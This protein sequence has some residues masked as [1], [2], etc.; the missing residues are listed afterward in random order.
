[1]AMTVQRNT[2]PVSDADRAAIL[3]D[4]GFGRYFTDHLV[5]IDWT[6][7]DGWDAGALLPYGPIPMDPATS[8]LHY[9]QLIFEGLQHN[10]YVPEMVVGAGLSISLA[11]GADALL[12]LL[13]RVVTPWARRSPTRGRA[14]VAGA[15]GGGA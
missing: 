12:L 6:R 5:R 1:M 4:P 8:S 13:L 14:V 9:G 10:L 15:P 2:H 3:A 7:D 11:L